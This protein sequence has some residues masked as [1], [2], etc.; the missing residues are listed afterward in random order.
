MYMYLYVRRFMSSHFDIHKEKK[1]YNAMHI[2][3][4]HALDYI[5]VYI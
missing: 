5:A 3:T 2:I 1:E 4:A